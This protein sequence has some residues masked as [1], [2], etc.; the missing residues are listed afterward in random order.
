[1]VKLKPYYIKKVG[2]TG[3]PSFLIFFFIPQSIQDSISGFT[4]R[5]QDRQMPVPY[6]WK[7]FDILGPAWWLVP[8]P[9]EKHERQ[10]GV[11]LPQFLGV[12]IKNISSCHH[13]NLTPSLTLKVWALF[14]CASCG[15]SRSRDLP[16]GRVV[17]E[18]GVSSEWVRSFPAAGKKLWGQLLLRRGRPSSCRR[19]GN[20]LGRTATSRRNFTNFTSRWTNQPRLRTVKPWIACQIN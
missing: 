19:W 3:L 10:N 8:N 2:L 9:S 4:G 14:S 16:T 20:A 12:N 7:T 18:P 6:R 5:S 1:M 13:K 17:P 11:H 15:L